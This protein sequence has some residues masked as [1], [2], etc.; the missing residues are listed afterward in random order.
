MA[1]GSPVALCVEPR[2]MPWPT[3]R[4][5]QPGKGC[6]EGSMCRRMVLIAAL[7][8]RGLACTAVDFGSTPLVTEDE[9]GNVKT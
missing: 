8:V 3:E 5:E 4:L 1:G 9:H 2:R 6:S 7:E